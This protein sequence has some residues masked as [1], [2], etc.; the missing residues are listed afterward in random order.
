VIKVTVQGYLTYKERVG[1]RQVSLPPGSSLAGL[2]AILRQDLAGLFDEQIFDASG[3]S[4]GRLVV[5]LNGMNFKHLPQG[6]STTL[7]D[8]DQVAI[9][10]P[11]AGG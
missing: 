3:E 9:F 10:P 8:G 1:K 5:M 7:K 11:L 2:L 6:L 4:S